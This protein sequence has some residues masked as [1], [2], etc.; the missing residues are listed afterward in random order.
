MK[1][2][3]KTVRMAQVHAVMFSFSADRQ[4]C[5]GLFTDPH[6]AL[7]IAKLPLG[8]DGGTGYVQV[9][10]LEVDQNDVPVKVLTKVYPSAIACACDNLTYNKC[11]EF[12][13]LPD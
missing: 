10:L 11:R 5:L 6:E 9:T 4:R 13:L 2:I 7:I 12:N 8:K 3:E 1:I